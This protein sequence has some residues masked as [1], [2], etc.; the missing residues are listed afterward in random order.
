[1]IPSISVQDMLLCQFVVEN[2]DLPQSFLPT[3]YPHTMEVQDV[4][5]DT[6]WTPAGSKPVLHMDW[7]QT[8]L[9]PEPRPMLLFFHADGDNIVHHQAMDRV[10]EAIDIVRELPGYSDVCSHSNHQEDGVYTCF[11]QGVTTFWNNSKTIYTDE[12]KDHSDLITALSELVDGRGRPVDLESILGYPVYES[13]G[14]TLASGKSYLIMFE[15]PEAD[16]TME[17][18]ETV[19]NTM[20]DLQVQWAAQN[21]N[22]YVEVQAERSFDDEFARAIVKDIP[23]V[24][25]VFVV[26]SIFTCSIFFKRDP[27]RSRCWMGFGAVVAVLLAIMTGYGLLFCI[28]VPFTSMTQILP[29]VMFGKYPCMFRRRRASF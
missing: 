7:I 28:G 11:I 8:E 29:F 3:T 24:P 25:L 27:V 16:G 20:L 4:N 1:M 13:D 22:F 14:V 15:V 12:V 21:I 6:L 17:L 18:E 19:I 2:F 26:M 23:L 10:F 5:E 9:P